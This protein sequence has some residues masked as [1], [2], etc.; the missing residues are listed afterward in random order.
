MD[1]R[2]IMSLTADKEDEDDNSLDKRYYPIPIQLKLFAKQFN[3]FIRGQTRLRK[4]ETT[5]SEAT[6]EE[7]DEE[8]EQEQEKWSKMDNSSMKTKQKSEP[9]EN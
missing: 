7:D 1:I 2:S 4:P 8:E 5:V 9:N 6:E 3:Q